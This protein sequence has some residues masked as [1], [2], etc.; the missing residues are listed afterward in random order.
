MLAVV[1]NRCGVISKVE[2]SA[3]SADGL[4]HLVTVDFSDSDGGREET[5]VWEREPSARIIE[6]TGLPRV[7]DTPCMPPAQFVAMVRASRWG[8]MHPYFDP[9]TSAG[10]LERLPL[11]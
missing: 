1:R 3:P 7:G 10:A 2:P 5:L 11:T 6:A 9:D 4:L 8:A